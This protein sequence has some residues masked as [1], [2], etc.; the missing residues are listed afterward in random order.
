MNVDTPLPQVA[1][2]LPADMARL[3]D[4]HDSEV[5]TSVLTKVRELVTDIEKNVTMDPVT[6]DAIMQAVV[7]HLVQAAIE[8][9]VVLTR[10]SAISH[11]A[12]LE[13]Q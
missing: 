3:L 1:M 9:Q 5:Q 8:W 13:L 4:T 12:N 11:L 7:P 6:F 10:L 2:H